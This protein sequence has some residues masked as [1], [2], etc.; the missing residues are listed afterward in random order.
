MSVGSYITLKIDTRNGNVC[1][2]EGPG[3]SILG[4]QAGELVGRDWRELLSDFAAKLGNGIKVYHGAPRLVGKKGD[5]FAQRLLHIQLPG[6][7]PGREQSTGAR[8]PGKRQ[9]K[10][11]WELL[12]RQ[13]PLTMMLWDIDCLEQIARIFGP[14]ARKKVL[15]HVS[16][17]AVSLVDDAHRLFKLGNNDFLFVITA[18]ADSQAATRQLFARLIENAS[19]P[20]K[21]DN[22]KLSMTINAG[23]V[24]YPDDGTDL[25]ELLKKGGQAIFKAQR[26]GRNT[27]TTYDQA[28]ELGLMQ[29]IALGADLQEAILTNKLE[30]YYQPQ[31]QITTGQVTGVEALLRWKHPVYGEI[32]PACFV[33]LAER[34][35]FAN[36]LTEWVLQHACRQGKKWLDDGL[37]FGRI[38]VNISANCFVG[39]WL[40]QA[41]TRVLADV[42]LDPQFLELEIT[43]NIEVAGVAGVREMLAALRRSGITIAFDDFGIGYSSFKYIKLFPLDTVKIDRLFVADVTHNVSSRAIVQ[44]VIRLAADLGLRTVAEGV[45]T[46][47]QLRFLQAAGCDSYQGYL[48]SPPAPVHDVAVLL[49]RHS[50]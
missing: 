49:C 38:A 7:V 42:G 9:L 37:R 24:R 31:A 27:W 3:L 29:E 18:K 50:G 44:A 4:C 41:V 45:E 26:S 17:Q 21:I 22:Y 12:T 39:G 1:S 25:D 15:K 30:L 34:S 23:L 14:E 11:E 33:P 13:A 43:E 16:R 20:L 2:A 6:A 28:M 40:N 36:R 46:G 8:I 47:E 32:P 10:R 35:G 19:Q 5:D 48:L